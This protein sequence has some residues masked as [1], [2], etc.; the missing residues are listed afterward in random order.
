MVT[1]F[2]ATVLQCNSH[3]LQFT[4]LK[5]PMVQWFLVCSE[6]HDRC[7]KQLQNF[8]SPQKE[9][10]CSLSSVPPHLPQFCQ[11]PATTSL[12]CVSGFD[13]FSGHFRSEGWNHAWCLVPGASHRARCPGLSHTAAA[14]PS[15]LWPSDIPLCVSPTF[16][17]SAHHGW[18]LGVWLL[19]M[20]LLWMP[21]YEFLRGHTP[22]SPSRAY[23]RAE[24][25]GRRLI[26]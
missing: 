5:C 3:I 16:C 13:C 14:P 6:S 25:P 19:D 22:S 12:L 2:I 17:L 4:Y 8:S 23:L 18:T 11:P 7:Q 20:K 10:P 15:F 24:L 21:T 9:P 1:I 26:T